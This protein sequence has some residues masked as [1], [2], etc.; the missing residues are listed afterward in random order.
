MYA[1]CILSLFIFSNKIFASQYIDSCSIRSSDYSVI[2]NVD[3][4]PTNSLLM[5]EQLTVITKELCGS[6]CITNVLCYTATFKIDTNQCTLYFTRMIAT[7]LIPFI[8]RYVLSA[9]GK[10]PGKN[11]YINKIS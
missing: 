2:E 11:F 7:Q 1:C 10:T 3:Y 4:Q 9:N 8:G 6:E 5:L